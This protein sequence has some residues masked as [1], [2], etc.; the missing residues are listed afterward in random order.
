MD[1]PV[2]PQHINRCCLGAR[3]GRPTGD[4]NRPLRASGGEPRVAPVAGVLGPARLAGW[5]AGWRAR[6]LDAR[7][8]PLTAQPA[9]AAQWPRPQA[10]PQQVTA[11]AQSAPRAAPN[12]PRA[13]AAHSLDHIAFQGREA[14]QSAL[15]ARLGSPC[16]VARVVPEGLTTAGHSVVQTR[17]GGCAALNG[18]QSAGAA[19]ALRGGL[20]IWLRS[21][22]RGLR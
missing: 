5:L 7:P 8:P 4:R 2:S 15:R 14:A 12:Q 18:E 10:R 20:F 13:A 3:R 21:V 17:T 9:A 19:L 22:S 1:R 11:I 16:A 6:R